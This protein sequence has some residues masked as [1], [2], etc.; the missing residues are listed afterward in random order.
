MKK[1]SSKKID[2]VFPSRI[3]D[4]I[5]SIPAALCL[6]QLNE[7]YAHGH[8][9]RVLSRPF[10]VELF[11]SLNLFKCRGMDFKEKARSIFLPADKAFFIETTNNNFGYMAKQAY[12]ITNPFKKF[13]KFHQE[14]IYLSFSA[15]PFPETWEKIKASFPTGL[16][17]FLVEKCKLP[18]YS[19]VLFGIC[20]DMGY[21]AE[22]VIETFDL[23]A[24]RCAH[25]DA[26]L[27]D[28]VVFCIEAG[29]GRKHLSERCW[30]IEG[31]YE[32]AQ[33]CHED[34]GL[35]SIFIGMGT[36][37]LPQ[38]PYIEDLRGKISIYE[39][40]CVM[41]KARMYIGN[42]TGPLHVANLMGTKSVAVYFKDEHMTGF[43]PIFPELNTRVFK[44]ETIEPI[45]SEVVKVLGH[46]AQKSLLVRNSA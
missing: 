42:D 19:T 7:K 38:K 13:L 45:Y 21:K 11:N 26:P 44:P 24:L 30:D 9:I 27:Q 6:G 4:S 8:K 37:P 43:H 29:Y 35:K 23:S 25:T 17:D 46:E 5:L 34:Y 22:Q 36:E 1:A 32:I 16:I 31:Y 12:G 28:Y 3:G 40:A 15:K 33:K 18:W 41:K 10:L 2:I 20:I 14:P 39:L